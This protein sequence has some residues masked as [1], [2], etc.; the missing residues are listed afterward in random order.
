VFSP[1][2]SEG[3]KEGSP[4]P[5]FRRGLNPDVRRPKVEGDEFKGVI[6][7][8]LL[9]PFHAESSHGGRPEVPKLGRRQ[10]HLLSEEAPQSGA[11]QGKIIADE[12][13][14][15]FQKGREVLE[16]LGG[17]LFFSEEA[18]FFPGEPGDKDFPPPGREDRPDGN[19]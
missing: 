12:E 14:R 17:I 3:W 15:S 18:I 8:L 11:L 9:K 6:E 4:A 10:Q 2:G 16:P 7:I 5:L 1:W 13:A 19:R